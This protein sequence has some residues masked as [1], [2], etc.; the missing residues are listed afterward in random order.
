MNFSISKRRKDRLIKDNRK[1]VYIDQFVMKEPAI[2]SKCNALYS[3]GRWT[4]KTTEMAASKTTCPACRRINDNYP[5]GYIEIK[6]SFFRAHS[7]DIINLI[8]NTGELEKN[9][10]PLERII[11]ITEKDNKTVIATT[12]IHIARRIGEA[13]KRSYQG[14]YSFQYANGEKSIRVFWEREI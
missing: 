2:C 10:R 9:E 12:G 3:S 8:N 6:G 4:W 13:L 5:A 7:A 1:D 11:Y 14:S